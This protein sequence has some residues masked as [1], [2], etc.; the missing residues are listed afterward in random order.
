MVDYIGKESMILKVKITI[1]ELLVLLLVLI[2]L[3]SGILMP[4]I[5]SARENARR[6]FCQNNIRQLT[7]A[8]QLYS[9]AN[10]GTL[11]LLGSCSYPIRHNNAVI[12]YYDYPRIN[13][14][15]TLFHYM[16]RSQEAQYILNT[17]YTIAGCFTDYENLQKKIPEIVC[18]SDNAP[19]WN[20]IST[21]QTM[22]MRDG[23][24]APRNYV[25]C[26]G[27]YPDAG[28]YQYGKAQNEETFKNFNWNSRTAIVP[29]GKNRK[30][31]DII[32]GL[33][34][35]IV[36]AERLRGVQGAR[37]FKHSVASGSDIV[38]GIIASPIGSFPQMLCL[39]VSRINNWENHEWDN[40]LCVFNN[41]GGTRAWCALT[42]YSTFQTLLPPNAPSCVSSN[43]G[44]PCLS[45]SSNHPGGVNIAKFDGSVSFISEFINANSMKL[46]PFIVQDG[47]SLYGVWGALGSIA[48]EEENSL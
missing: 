16:N 17:P 22:N 5:S 10:D 47:P 7:A 27:D 31:S 28:C 3:V 4:W 12:Q 35:T 9:D 32:D 48:G 40:S 6:L 20:F 39:M 15:V 43:E 41:E 25:F 30:L 38:P 2:V 23:L 24:L 14:I 34:N 13:S 36:F 26:S 21:G 33:G 1:I 46:E 44:R 19:S 29:M 42:V 18:P 45:A 8:L 11:P 37:S